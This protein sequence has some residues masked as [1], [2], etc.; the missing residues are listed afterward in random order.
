[1]SK[2]CYPPM[3]R[4]LQMKKRTT[5]KSPVP[6]KLCPSNSYWLLSDLLH[7]PFPLR[8]DVTNTSFLFL[9]FFQFIFL[10]ASQR[11]KYVFFFNLDTRV[12]S[13]FGIWKVCGSLVNFI[14]KQATPLITC[15]NF[16]KLSH[17]RVEIMSH[18]GVLCPIHCRTKSHLGHYVHSIA[19]P[20]HIQVHNYMKSR[21]RQ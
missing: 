8:V 12:L 5:F 6:I 15:K 18:S 17:V 10:N 21:L 7:P 1:M 2:I 9:F 16:S 20:S 4:G 3:D 11:L 14:Y 13:H 19:G